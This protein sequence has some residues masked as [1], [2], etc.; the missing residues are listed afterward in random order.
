MIA[1]YAR[2]LLVAERDASSR[3]AISAWFRR[4][5]FGVETAS[6]GEEAWDRIRSGMSESEPAPRIDLAFLDDELPRTPA[7]EVLARAR[8]QEIRLPA[9]LITSRGARWVEVD[10]ELF[11]A[12]F[13]RPLGLVEILAVVERVFARR[14]PVR[15]TR[16]PRASA[17]GGEEN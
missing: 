11:E 12:V 17:E 7:R 14:L 10:P 9:I 15:I 4:R 13:T 1:S 5:G 2:R 6:D 16:P 8:T 3:E